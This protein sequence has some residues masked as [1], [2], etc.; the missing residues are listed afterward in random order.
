METKLTAQSGFIVIIPN[1]F[2]VLVEG[3]VVGPFNTAQQSLAWAYEHAKDGIF[4]IK[5]LIDP[6]MEI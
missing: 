3:F 4:T 5:E 1:K 2:V 6:K